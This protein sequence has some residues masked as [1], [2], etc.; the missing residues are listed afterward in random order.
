[1]FVVKIRNRGKKSET[2][3]SLTD[4]IKLETRLIIEN[5]Q[6]ILNT[7]FIQKKRR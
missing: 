7:P 3:K 1:M 5:M 2:N 4:Q 6:R